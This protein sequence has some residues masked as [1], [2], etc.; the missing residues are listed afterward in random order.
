[1]D[2]DFPRRL[3]RLMD[4]RGLATAADL[5]LFAGVSVTAA[6]SWLKG[7]CMPKLATLRSLKRRFRCPWED[8]L[9]R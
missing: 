1:M 2:A 6:R 9:G 4:S 5:A 3:R 8:L 7:E